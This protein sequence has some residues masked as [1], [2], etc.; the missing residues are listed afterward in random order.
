L[1]KRINWVIGFSLFK[2]KEGLWELPEIVKTY[3][4][5]P[6]L[7]E[8]ESTILSMLR[9][10]LQSMRML[11]IGVGAGRTTSSFAPLALE[12]VGVDSSKAMIRICRQKYPRYRFEVADA[13]CME[14]FKDESF[15]FVLFSFNGIDCATHE[16]RLK[17]LGEVHRITRN[18]GLFFFSTHNLNSTWKLY[19]PKLQRDPLSFVH[20][21]LR[22][23]L[24]R[25]VNSGV[26]QELR[27]RKSKYLIFND[28][29]H[30]FNLKMYYVTPHEQVRQLTDAGFI[31]IKIYSNSDGREIRRHS[32]EIETDN[33]L[34][35]LCNAVH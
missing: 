19:L 13:K 27:T 8:P 3:S 25:L 12:Y 15:D 6:F 22:I 28:G 11:D 9:N 5:K 26:W 35:Y 34:Y 20:E 16:E 18:K 29:A 31:N 2:S 7:F 32:R 1:K 10:D 4:M 17:I 33:W 23:V 14:L 21:P 24:M 30:M